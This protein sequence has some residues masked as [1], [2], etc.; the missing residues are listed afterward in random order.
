MDPRHLTVPAVLLAL[1]AVWN[2]VTWAVYRLDKRRARTGRGAR[3]IPERV[4]LGL[5]AVGGSPGALIAVYAHRQRHKAQK[6]GF[7][8]WLWG[9]VV[10]QI[11]AAGL[12]AYALRAGRSS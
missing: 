1:L 11:A 2:V 5:A 8:L 4:L 3:R 9:I 6:L 10:V 7:V 12:V